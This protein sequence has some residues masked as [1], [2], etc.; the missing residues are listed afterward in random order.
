MTHLDI[1]SKNVM[2]AGASSVSV[3]EVEC[4]NPE[5]MKFEALYNE[6]VNFLANQ[7]GDYRSNYPR[8]RGN[9]EMARPKV[10]G[11]NMPPRYTKAKNFRKDE[12]A[13]NPSKLDNDGKKPCANKKTNPRDPSVPS[14]RRG[15]FTAIHSSL[16]AHDFDNLS[17]S[18]AAE[19]SKEASRAIVKFQ[20]DTQGTDAPTDG[21]TA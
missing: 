5:E 19:S 16:I 1:L 15:F 4:T 13:T 14:W 11:R 2:G 21:A 20:K 9:Q 10:T 18:V 7:G 12:K 17:K 3:V 6:E 8:H